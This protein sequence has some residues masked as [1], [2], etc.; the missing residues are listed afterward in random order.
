M[1]KIVAIIGVIILVSLYIITF[2]VAILNKPGS[3]Q[4]FKACI[5]ATIMIPI[6]IYVY[7]WIYKLIKKQ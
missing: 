6:L 5:Y 3:E 4:L 7:I 1:K 2:I